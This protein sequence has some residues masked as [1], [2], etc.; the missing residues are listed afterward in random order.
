VRHGGVGGGA[1]LFEWEGGDVW[2]I[3]RGGNAI[4]G[5]ARE[6]AA[7]GGDLPKRDGV[8]LSRRLDVSGRG[9]R[10]VGQRIMDDRIG[11]KHDA[12]ARG[13]KSLC[14]GRTRAAAADFIRGAGAAFRGG[15]STGF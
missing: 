3:V 14:A 1:S 2:R 15:G 12:A 10:T 4:S 8:E 13:K 11:E 5:G 7:P 9:V 6:A